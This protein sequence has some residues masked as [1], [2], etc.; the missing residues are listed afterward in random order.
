MIRIITSLVAVL[1]IS[2]VQAQTSASVRETPKLVIGITIDQLR[3][4]YLELFQNT[5]T[6]KGFKRLLSEGLVYQNIRFD[7]P[8]LDDAS[9]IAT[10]YTGATPFYHGIVGNKKYLAD[11]QQEITTFSDPSFLGN[12]TQDKV[13]PL[14]LK[15]STITDEIKI[16]SRGS[17]D[18][19]SFAPHI[20]QALI[21]AGQRGTGAYWVDDYS[22]KWASTTFYKNFYLYVDMEN[23]NSTSDFSLKAWAMQWRP[24]L[25]IESYKAFPFMQGVAP[26]NHNMGTDK[27]TYIKAKQTPAVNEN[28]V[29]MATTVLA[30]AE[31]G[32]RV[33]LDFLSV[34]LYA[35]NYKDV[36]DYSIE[37]QDTYARL[38]REIEKLLDEVDK[39]V[40]LKNTL[41]FLTSTG[42]YNSNETDSKYEQNTNIPENKFYVNRCE[43]LLNMYLMAIYGKDGKWIDKFYNGQVY[44]N[45]E[46][47]KKKEISLEEIQNKAAEFVSEFTGVQDV[48]T[49]YQI[50]HGQWNPIMEFYKNGYTKETSGDLF[51]ELQPGYKVVNEQDASF[52]E[53][54]VRSNAI[55]CPVIFFGNGIKPQKIRRTIKAT[56]IAPT[57]SYIMRIRSPNAAKEEALSELL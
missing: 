10:I 7:I 14:A 47:I 16:A 49:S 3:G 26:F 39:T 5:F 56:E 11:K 52:K 45:R 55:V 12:Y 41:I 18:V 50:Q 2:S 37:I 4:D 8:N 35:G 44:L 28:V 13:S 43:A 34:T 36:P 1:T 9:A 27:E 48:Y 42:Y 19:Y 29:K 17:S 38:D 33:N 25:G 51:V 31:L 23:R 54:Q 53:K 15:T 46:L 6:E 40:G 22:G 32:R 21:T 30:K 57:I 24:L 20:S